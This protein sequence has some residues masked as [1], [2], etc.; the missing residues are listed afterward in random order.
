MIIIRFNWDIVISRPI[1]VIM[2]TTMV[3]N[4]CYDYS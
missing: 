2:I 4:S 3:N 1:K